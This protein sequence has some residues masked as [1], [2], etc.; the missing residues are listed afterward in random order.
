MFSASDVRL[1]LPSR[2]QAFAPPC[3]PLTEMSDPKTWVGSGKV[4]N[5]LLKPKLLPGGPPTGL[6]PGMR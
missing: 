1:R 3:P 4:P 6:T 2:Y 5:S